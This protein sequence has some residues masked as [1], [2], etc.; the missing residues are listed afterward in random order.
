MLLSPVQLLAKQPAHWGSTRFG[1]IVLGP[2]LA[3]TEL[4]YL[5]HSL[6]SSPIDHITDQQFP[7]NVAVLL[8]IPLLGPQV[9]SSAHLNPKVDQVFGI[10]L[11]PGGSML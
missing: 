4:L 10:S 3:H 2:L 11:R 1:I 8:S 9:M 6:F 7:S 5:L